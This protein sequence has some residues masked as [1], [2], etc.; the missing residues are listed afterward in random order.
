MKTKL[1]ISTLVDLIVAR[2]GTD[3]TQP[4]P[5]NLRVGWRTDQLLG[6]VDMLVINQRN[7]PATYAELVS[8]ALRELKLSDDVSPE[9]IALTE[10]A[11]FRGKRLLPVN[12]SRGVVLD[13]LQE[14]LVKTINGLPD[15]PR[16][17]RCQ[18]LFEY[19][20]GVFCTAYGR[21]ELSARAQ[22]RSAGMARSNGD[23][24]GGTIGDFMSQ[25]YTFK[26]ELVQ[27]QPD[28]ES[29][30]AA[31][32]ESYIRLVALVKGTA[33]E[34]PWGQGNGPWHMIEACIW[35][36]FR[37]PEWGVLV[38]TYLAAAEKLGKAW[39]PAAN[40]VRAVDS[41]DMA[42]L[43]EI[44]VDISQSNE[45]RATAF[46]ALVQFNQVVSG[47]EIPSGIKTGAQH[48]CAVAERRLK[49]V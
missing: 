7:E 33:M 16:K 36:D 46:L 29:K 9:V 12:P 6:D 15:G 34:V 49:G 24:A 28:A 48:V 5:N 43:R 4:D 3:T 21:F 19:N 39:E 27:G 20:F 13:R 26:H 37:S 41:G 14:G 22:L 42:A 17:V 45:N 10:L 2:A 35:L 47:S 31:L 38:A 23:I 40:L 11:V 32:R 44:V 8:R 18:S 25:F 1:N 30:I